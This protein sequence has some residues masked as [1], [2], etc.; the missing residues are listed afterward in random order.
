MS[1][2]NFFINMGRELSI[3]KKNSAHNSNS[4]R[5]LQFHIFSRFGL[6]KS[7]ISTS[8]TINASSLHD[9][10]FY[11]LPYHMFIYVVWGSCSW[12][13]CFQCPPARK[14]FSIS[15][16]ASTLQSSR[17]MYPINWLWLRLKLFIKV[18]FPNSRWMGPL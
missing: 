1:A 13:R 5:V 6:V 4:M 18:Q 12:W 16:R 7:F 14:V 8:E 3:K 11:H 15:L 17:G 9:E 2:M 10:Q